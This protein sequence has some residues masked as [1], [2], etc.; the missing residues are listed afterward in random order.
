MRHN[1]FGFHRYHSRA[2]N[3][4]TN[5]PEGLFVAVWRLVDQKLVTAREEWRYWRNRKW[6]EANLP[7]PPFYDA[8]NPE[9]AI[10]WYKDTRMGNEMSRR[11]TFYFRL[12]KKYGLPIEKETTNNPGRIIYEDEYQVGSLRGGREDRN[13]QHAG[14]ADPR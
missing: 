6:F 12:A 13:G 1:Q 14:S 9:G 11:M 10:T 4:R 2:V 7:I 3:R 8:G 5:E